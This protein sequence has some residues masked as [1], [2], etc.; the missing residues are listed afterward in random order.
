MYNDL[1]YATRILRK[2]PGFTAAA[3]VTLALGIGANTAIFSVLHAV[4]LRALPYRDADRLVALRQMNLERQQQDKV[5]CGDYS[6]WKTRSH[7]FEEM[8]YS[9]DEPYTLTGVGSPRS[10]AGYQ[11]SANLF[12]LLGAQPI[13]GRTFLAE[14]DQ[15]GKDRVVV[16]SYRLWQKLFASDREVVGRSIQLNGEAYTVIGVMPPEFAHPGTFVD[17]WTPL[18]IPADW[19]Q[20]RRLHLL[21]VV[22]RLRPGVGLAQARQELETLAAD[23]AKQYPETNRHWSARVFPIRDLYAG[24]LQQAL[25]ILQVSVLLMLLIACANVANMLLAQASSRE[26]EVAIRLALGAGRGHLFSQFLTQGLILSSLGAAGGLLLAFW[27]VQVLPGMFSAQLGGISLPTGP[28]GWIDG[29]VLAFTLCI[30]VA[31]GALFGLVPAIRAPLLP[32]DALKGGVRGFSRHTRSFRLRDLLIVSQVALSLM[33]LVGSGLLI[34]SFLRLQEQRLGFQ[35]DRVLASFLLLA[36]NRYPDLLATST[37]L[38]QVLAHLQGLPGVES[39]AAISTLP[40]SGNDARRPFTV[41]G[42]PKSTGQQNISQFR[43][44]TPD[45]F[46]AMRIPLR[47]GRLFDERDRKGAPEV[48]IINERLAR[49]LW[50]N[51]DPVG[52]SIFVPDMLEPEPRQIVGVVG[53]VR[54]YGLAEEPPIEIYRPANQA[55]WPFFTLVVRGSVNPMQLANSVRQAV[56]SVDKDQPIESVRTMEQLASESVALPRASMV[57]LASFAGVAVFLA[58][59]GIYSVMSYTVTQRTQEIGLRMALGA[60]GS[61]ILKLVTGEAI[62]VALMGVGLGLIGAF[63]LTRFLVSLLYAVRPTDPGTFAAVSILLAAV[64]LVASYVPA[65]KATKVDPMVALR[66]D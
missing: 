12:S 48:V 5:T 53:D 19:F 39:A 18:L 8:A 45:Y 1:R 6:D 36:R 20:S 59:L 46:R 32:Q 54:H 55:Y 33:L 16:L 27:G 28:W 24:N 40:L 57:L 14:E 51:E 29:P 64:A 17:L 10:V 23:L 22:A 3:V 25:W 30:A 56:G 52:K 13:L 60:R 35:T 62:R 65:R 61:D 58:A 37:F 15:P 43:L 9:M 21:H 41:P 38:E 31:A 2:N 50:P 44:V 63:L 11:F 4:L 49:R 34:R 7:V 26:R 42:Q 47:K 66:C